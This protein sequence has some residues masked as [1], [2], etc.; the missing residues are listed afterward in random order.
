MPRHLYANLFNNVFY[1][2]PSHFVDFA[3]SKTSTRGKS[4]VAFKDGAG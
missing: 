1:L 4:Y 2:A 3:F